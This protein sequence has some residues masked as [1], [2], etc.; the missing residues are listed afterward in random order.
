MPIE[1]LHPTDKENI[2][3]GLLDIIQHLNKSGVITIQRMCF[4]CHF[5]KTNKNGKEHFCGLLNTKLADSELR[6]DCPEH[7]LKE[8][9]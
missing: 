4:T 5:Y 6:I 8:T 9:S 7:S 3:L 2:L 1:K